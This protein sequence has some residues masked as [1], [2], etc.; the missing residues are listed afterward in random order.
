VTATLLPLLQG[1]SL[2]AS[3]EAPPFRAKQ[4]SALRCGGLGR[5]KRPVRQPLGAV[6]GVVVGRMP[7]PRPVVRIVSEDDQ[8]V[9]LT[10]EFPKAF[11][12]A[13]GIIA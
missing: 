13:L 6:S 2:L 4:H 11:E 5:A 1:A 12:R 8:R 7:E 10:R 3:S 9:G